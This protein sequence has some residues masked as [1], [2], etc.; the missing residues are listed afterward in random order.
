M[1]HGAIGG[2]WDL[3]QEDNQRRLLGWAPERRLLGVTMTPPAHFWRRGD[4]AAR[5][6]DHIG[7]EASSKEIHRVVDAELVR[8]VCKLARAR[9][10][11]RGRSLGSARARAR[12]LVSCDACPAPNRVPGDPV[13]YQQ[14]VHVAGQGV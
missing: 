4:S 8:F 5:C 1:L 11:R 9:V 12:V 14:F 13:F 3:L 10:S 2:D 7:A 6:A